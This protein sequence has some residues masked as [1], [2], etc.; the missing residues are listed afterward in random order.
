LQAPITDDLRNFIHA[1]IHSVEQ[2][3]ILLLLRKERSRGFTGDEVARELR[4][5]PGSASDRLE[6]LRARGLAR[7]DGERTI[8][9]PSTGDFE[10]LVNAIASAYS[11]ARVA[12]I[13]T[14]F[15]KPDPLRS[16]ADA[17]KLGGKK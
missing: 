8:Y 2:L 14:I 5:H 10:R 7:L 6:D 12:V 15:S 1:H 4:I 3:E 17:F 11:D 16:F 9:A 13:Q